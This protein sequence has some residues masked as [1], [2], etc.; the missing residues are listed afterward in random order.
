MMPDRN[1]TATA[2]DTFTFNCA[3]TTITIGAD[4][5]VIA[6]SSDV[7][8]DDDIL[9]MKLSTAKDSFVA[10]NVRQIE[11]REHYWIKMIS[12]LISTLTTLLITFVFQNYFKCKGCL[13]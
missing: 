10:L 13:I 3:S 8:P 11:G 5:V 2:T 4:T 7:N 12:S 9:I 1:V 6:Y